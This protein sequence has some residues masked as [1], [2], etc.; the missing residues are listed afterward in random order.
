NIGGGGSTV[1]EGPTPDGSS[2][3]FSLVC[4]AGGACNNGC[5]GSVCNVGPVAGP[6]PL[7]TTFPD[8]TTTGCNFGTPLPVPNFNNPSLTTCALNT[9]AAP[10]TGTIDLSTGASSTSVPL[11]SD[12]SLTGIPTQPCPACLPLGTPPFTGTCNRGPRAGSTCTSTSSTGF[13]RDCPTGGVGTPTSVCPGGQQPANGQTCCSPL[14]A[15]DGLTPCAVDAD[16]VAGG[17]TGPCVQPSHCSNNAATACTNTTDCVAP[18][19]CVP[20]NCPCTAGGGGCC[21]GGHVGPIS[22]TLSPL[23]TGPASTTSSVGRFCTGQLAGTHVGCFGNTTCRQINEN[24]S[25]AG[26]VL[27]NVPGNPTPRAGFCIPPTRNSGGK[28]AADLR[29]A[30]A[31]GLPCGCRA[32]TRPA[33]APRSARKARAARFR[34]VA[35]APGSCGT[36]GLRSSRHRCGRIAGVPAGL[37]RLFLSRLLLSTGQLVFMGGT[38]EAAALTRAWRHSSAGRRWCARVATTSAAPV[39][40]VIASATH[41]SCGRGPQK[42]RA[43]RSPC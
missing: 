1:A 8:C 2:S 4:A 18:G 23:T 39:A 29:A 10:G 24:G 21:D 41:S 33:T 7:N 6:P 13:T 22:V 40:T 42:T 38:T 19:I 35:E 31:G 37:P 28:G 34:R 12:V 30:G 15:G 11:T 5:A 25:A 14:C 43:V 17:T 32:N 20:C 26:Q 36:R 3:L 27:T 9:F 16:C